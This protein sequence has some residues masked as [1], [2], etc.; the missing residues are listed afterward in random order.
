MVNTDI[1]ALSNN[2][3]EVKVSSSNLISFINTVTKVMAIFRTIKN[4]QT[5]VTADSLEPI[6]PLL[7]IQK[8]M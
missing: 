5:Q 2:I 4:K 1:L 7:C 6:F 8:I 3:G